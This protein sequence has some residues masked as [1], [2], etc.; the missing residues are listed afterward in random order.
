MIGGVFVL[1]ALLRSLVSK[2]HIFA[3]RDGFLSWFLVSQLASAQFSCLAA[4]GRIFIRFVLY[5]RLND[6]LSKCCR[7]PL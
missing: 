1:F 4:L 7:G 2:L 5:I 3:G 6:Y